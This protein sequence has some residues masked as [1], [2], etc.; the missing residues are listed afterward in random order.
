MTDDLI[1]S[2]HQCAINTHAA[3]EKVGKER[4]NEFDTIII[5]A[6]KVKRRSDVIPEYISMITLILSGEVCMV[7][8]SVTTRASGHPG[9]VLLLMEVCEATN[10]EIVF[11]QYIHTE[12][13]TGEDLA[14]AEQ[15]RFYAEHG[16][17]DV[18]IDECKTICEGSHHFPDMS[19][20]AES[21]IG[22]VGKGAMLRELISALECCHSSKKRK[23]AATEESENERKE[24]KL[25]EF[26]DE[27]WD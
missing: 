23:S 5:P 11:S 25:L 18:Y 20:L 2:V 13:I 6:Y 16:A 21:K 1:V 26:F 12:G 8:M 14:V 19:A 4:F 10:T 3:K 15:K 7:V 24:R 9:Y 22:N 17:F 27:E